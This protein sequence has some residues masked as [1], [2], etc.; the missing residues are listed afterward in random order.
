MNKAKDGWEMRRRFNAVMRVDDGPEFRGRLKRGDQRLS[1]PWRNS[2][3]DAVAFAY[4]NLRIGKLQAAHAS[5][6]EDDFPKTFAE[7][8]NGA[9]AREI[10]K[11]RLYKR[12]GKA[13][14]NKRAAGR[15]SFR[16]GVPHDRASK[17]CGALVWIGV[18]SGKY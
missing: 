13:F 6:T 17:P 15:A 3:N 12:R 1:G 14:G 8:D 4:G 10:G 11:R 18:E 16:K 2:E 9:M 5:R 7:A